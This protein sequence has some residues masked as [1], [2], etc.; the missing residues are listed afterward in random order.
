MPNIVIG[1]NADKLMKTFAKLCVF[2]GVSV[3]TNITLAYLLLLK[4]FNKEE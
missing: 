1:I 4:T 2:S 3:L